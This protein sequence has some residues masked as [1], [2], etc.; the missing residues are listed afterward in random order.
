MK[1]FLQN[2]LIVFALGLCALVAFQWHREGRLRADLQALRDAARADRETIQLLQGEAQRVDSEIVRTEA[3]WKQLS[4]TVAARKAEAAR[5]AEELQKRDQLAAELESFK[6]ALARA[7]ENITAQNE[8]MKALA[9]ERNELATKFNQLAE[10]YNALV[11][12]WND[13][14]EQLARSS[15][16]RN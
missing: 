4:E 15:P 6:A 12:R 14:Q 10:D 7:N 13:Q 9:D 8:A 1:N 16:V 5:L 11:K 3:Q 2:L